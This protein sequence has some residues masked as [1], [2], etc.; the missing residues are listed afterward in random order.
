MRSALPPFVSH[1]LVLTPC[2]RT[3]PGVRGAFEK[4]YD[5][6]DLIVSFDVMNI[7]FPNRKD[8]A[9]NKPWAHQ[10]QDPDTTGFRCLQ[11]LVNLLPCGDNDG[12]LI[13]MPGAHLISDE[14]HKEFKNEE[15]IWQW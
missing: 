13:I 15:R 2:C 5:T 10:D 3:E 12:G 1:K 6:E 4:V 11:G 14:F 8:L 7:S 9:P